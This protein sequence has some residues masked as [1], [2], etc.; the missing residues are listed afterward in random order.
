MTGLYI[1]VAGLFGALMGAAQTPP[2]ESICAG[3]H[4]QAQKVQAEK[5]QSTAHAP[6][7]CVGC[8]KQHEEYPH[9]A[10]MAKP[11]CGS[12]HSRIAGEH[13]RG[14]HGQARAAGNQGAPDCAVC[15]GAAHEIVK[16]S[17][18]A[19][20][21]GVPETC[22]M[23]HSEVVTQFQVSVHG[24]ALARGV[25]NAPI[26]TTCHGEH[27]ILG[28]KNEAS[29]V[30]VRHVRE[31]C[32]QC[33]GSAVLARKFGLPA[34]RVLS[35]DASFHGL[36]AKSGSQSVANCASCHGVHNI[37]PSADPKSTVNAKNLPATCGQCHTGAGKRFTIGPVHWVEGKSEPDAVRWVRLLYALL[38][39]GVIGLML[40]HNL[41]D[42][43]RKLTQLRFRAPTAASG[44]EP[45]P[46]GSGSSVHTVRMYPAERAQHAL[47]VLSFLTLAWTGFA[48]K[49][50]DQWWTRPLLAWESHWP[51]RATVHRIA[52]AIFMLVSVAHV[53]ALFASARLRKHW[54]NLAPRAADAADAVRMFSYN[55]GLRSTRPKLRPYSYIEKAEYWALVWGGGV[56]ILTGVALW[57]ENLM[58]AWLPKAALD[59]AT[60]VHFYEAVLATLA[61]LVWHFY[62]VIFDPEVYP[63]DTAWYTGVSARAE[64]SEEKDATPEAAAR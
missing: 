8:H 9:P 40:L 50:P 14:V 42:W 22:G 21:Q 39:P 41:G 57:G 31:T 28:P 34:D 11:E 37:L 23:C 15:H 49:Y 47:L 51:V 29:P 5:M 36:A 44:I 61:I 38:I 26:C 24:R 64:E 4:E 46:E 62:F 60:A 12:C 59:V 10:G 16:T 7:H 17:S 53:V 52:G 56:M 2:A 54:M 6:L 13:A 45:R 43:V 30:N 63:M 18:P 33:H 58:L 55:V 19:F 20:H 1:V 3:C 35:F 27:S 25:T 32:A 48:L